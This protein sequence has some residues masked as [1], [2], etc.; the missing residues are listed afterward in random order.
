MLLIQ[1]NIQT[2]RLDIDHGGTTSRWSPLS[3]GNLGL[4]SEEEEEEKWKE[5]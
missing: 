1:F 4:S 3:K 2:L 5:Q